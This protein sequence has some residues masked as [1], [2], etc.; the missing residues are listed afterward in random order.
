MF[1]VL[2]R[3]L[4]VFLFHSIGLRTEE[5]EDS[6]SVTG[7]VLRHDGGVDKMFLA[8]SLAKPGKCLHFRSWRL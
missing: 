1:Q 5:R 4:V 8:E 6:G 2:H 7:E 3:W